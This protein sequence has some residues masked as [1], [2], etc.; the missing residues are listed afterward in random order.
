MKT[1]NYLV[2]IFFV[3]TLV[4]TMA[5]S[6]RLVILTFF[7][8]KSDYVKNAQIHEPKVMIIPIVILSAFSFVTGFWG[9]NLANFMGVPLEFHIEP[10][11]LMISIATFLAGGIPLYFIYIRRS[12][13]PEYFGRGFAGTVQKLFSNGYYFDRVYN[14]VFVNGLTAGVQKFRKTHPGILNYN[15]ILIIGGLSTL[16]ILFLLVGGL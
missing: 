16:V 3:L 14:A 8:E 11:T 12:P 4:V 7:G 1:G 5:Y 10:L 2:P 13:S 9:P 6:W 15:I